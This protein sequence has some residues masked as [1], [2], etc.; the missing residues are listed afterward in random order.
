MTIA[1]KMQAVI[2]LAAKQIGD[3]DSRLRPEVIAERKAEVV[4][5]RRGEVNELLQDGLEGFE[6]ERVKAA[7]T[8]YKRRRKRG[9]QTQLDWAEV[10]ARSGWIQEDVAGMA[11]SAIPE[12]Y[13]ELAD[14]GDRLGSWLV[15]RYGLARLDGLLSNSNTDRDSVTAAMGAR[16]ALAKAAWGEEI[17]KHKA[18]LTTIRRSENEVRRLAGDDQQMIDDARARFGIRDYSNAP[19]PSVTIRRRPGHKPAG[20]KRSTG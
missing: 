14:L 4:A 1:E 17:V 10:V 8:D 6:A 11:L 5:W 15:Q 19:E 18:A 3:I 13:Q 20:G 16:D 9:P 2:D 12:R 7:Q